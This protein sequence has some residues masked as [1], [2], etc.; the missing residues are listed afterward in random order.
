M[1]DGQIPRK[2]VTTLLKITTGIG[3]TAFV[4]KALFAKFV[5][6]N[7][8]RRQILGKV[9]FSLTITRFVPFPYH[10]QKTF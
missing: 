1:D 10:I 2:R 6:P 3:I 5:T 7:L 9:A 4:M 8:L